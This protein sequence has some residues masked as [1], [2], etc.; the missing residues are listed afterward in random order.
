[1]LDDL[2]DALIVV[3]NRYA[4]GNEDGRVSTACVICKLDSD[5]LI[6]LLVGELSIRCV[7]NVGDELL[8]NVDVL[9]EV[10]AEIDLVIVELSGFTLDVGCLLAEQVLIHCFV[11]GDGVAGQ[12]VGFADVM[13]AF[14]KYYQ[15]QLERSFQIIV[16]VKDIISFDDGL[17]P[18]RVDGY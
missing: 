18:S 10:Q 13:K 17:C 1:M 5:Q 15:E 16:V 12:D 4:G 7:L 11:D 9:S 8:E 6:A 2:G 3:V 14:R